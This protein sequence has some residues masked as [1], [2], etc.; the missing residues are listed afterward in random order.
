M[1]AILIHCISG[2]TEIDCFDYP[3]KQRRILGS[4]GIQIVEATVSTIKAYAKN[5][6]A[7]PSERRAAVSPSMATVTPGG[8]W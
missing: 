1:T 6:M 7:V 4:K 5:W 3:A 2:C 8:S